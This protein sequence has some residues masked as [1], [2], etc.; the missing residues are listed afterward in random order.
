MKATFEPST[1]ASVAFKVVTGPGILRE[2]GTGYILREDGGMLMRED[3][4]VEQ[5]T[6]AAF[7]TSITMKGTFDG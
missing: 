6:S 7:K 4:P 1:S 2:D 3:N 5:K